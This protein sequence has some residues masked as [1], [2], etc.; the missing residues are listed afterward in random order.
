MRFVLGLLT[1]LALTGCAARKPVP[2]A[3]ASSP[4]ADRKEA[5]DK[6]P[7]APA[8]D[9]DADQDQPGATGDPCEGGK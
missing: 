5:D 9:A 1:I 3:A 6:Q 4:S 7:P 2:R 8:P